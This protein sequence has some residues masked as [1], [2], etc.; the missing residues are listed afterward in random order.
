MEL[1]LGGLVTSCKGG[2]MRM[3]TWSELFLFAAFVV[4]LIALLKNKDK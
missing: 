2:V 4:A 1:P 3:I